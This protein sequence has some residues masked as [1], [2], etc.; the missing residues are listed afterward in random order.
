MIRTKA[1][2]IFLLG[3]RMSIDVIGFRLVYTRGLQIS[4][5]RQ[6]ISLVSL[7]SLSFVYAWPRFSPPL[8]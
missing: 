8:I 2:G 6:Y 4:Q 1:W 5:D 3:V 7:Y